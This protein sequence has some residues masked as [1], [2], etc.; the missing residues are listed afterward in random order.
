MESV[1]AASILHVRI[2]LK[3]PFQF[4]NPCKGASDHNSDNAMVM[5]NENDL[6]AC[7]FETFEAGNV[8]FGGVDMDSPSR[9]RDFN[10][11]DEGRYWTQTGTVGAGELFSRSSRTPSSPSSAGNSNGAA[12]R[13]SSRRKMVHECRTLCQQIT[14]FEKDFAI[15]HSR[16]L[17][18]S[19]KGHMQPVYSKYRNMKR[20]FRSS[21]A[22]DIQR[23]I[24]AFICRA[25]LRKSTKIVPVSPSRF[26]RSPARPSTSP[27]RSG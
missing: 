15:V 22:V 27:G 16:Q 17:K 3:D 7:T 8:G 9:D 21:A 12:H 2:V 14:K 1:R 20:E 19:E 18:G 10:D 5:S 24:R 25:K 26:S 11:T 6:M 4:F 23:F 13:A